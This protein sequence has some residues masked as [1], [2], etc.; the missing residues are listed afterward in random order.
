MDRKGHDKIQ[1]KAIFALWIGGT[2]GRFC[3]DAE[4]AETG[5]AAG[6]NREERTG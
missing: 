1:V 2:L 5:R 3:K 4:E 6:K